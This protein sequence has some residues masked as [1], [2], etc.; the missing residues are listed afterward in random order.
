M[1]CAIVVLIFK[2]IITI[3]FQEE[4]FG[5]L[6]NNYT[7]F[8]DKNFASFGW[9]SIM[10]TFHCCG[11]KNYTDFEG[12]YY[13]IT[14]GRLY[15]K[16][17]CRNPF[18]ADCDGITISSEIIFTKG[19]FASVTAMI[20]RNSAVIGGAAIGI[21]LIQVRCIHCTHLSRHGGTTVDLLPY[22]ARDPGS[23]LTTGA[24]C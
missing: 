16:S 17:C 14:K 21:S 6:K 18:S 13:Q 1:T 22:S 8:G 12:S 24:V 5:L 15:P 9:D 7:G 23:I 2:S 20:K 4:A 19:C 3:L 11:L 10:K